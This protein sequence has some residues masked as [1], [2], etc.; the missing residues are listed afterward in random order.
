MEASYEPWIYSPILSF[1]FICIGLYYSIFRSWL[2][3]S[4]IILSPN[5]F[6]FITLLHWQLIA[7][8]WFF[9]DSS[10]LC[11]FQLIDLPFHK[12]C[13]TWH[14]LV[15]ERGIFLSLSQYQMNLCVLCVLSVGSNAMDVPGK[16]FAYYE[17]TAVHEIN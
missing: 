14:V 5:F 3:C 10:C 4:V 2:D 15:W 9:G 16:P 1:S 12:S 8:N 7:A 6:L 17:T 13:T 11:N